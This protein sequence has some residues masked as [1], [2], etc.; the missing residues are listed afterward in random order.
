MDYLKVLVKELHMIYGDVKW[1]FNKPIMSIVE[2][3]KGVIDPVRVYT[4]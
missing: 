2:F 4:N 1:K 3:L